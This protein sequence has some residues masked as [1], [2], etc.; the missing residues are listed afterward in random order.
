MTKKITFHN[1]TPEELATYV[2]DK[3]EELRALQFNVAGSK[4]KNVKA[5]RNLRKEIARALTET[6]ARKTKG[7]EKEYEF[8]SEKKSSEK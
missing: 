3:R 7:H 5:A 2:N 6:N 4:N 1:H 8:T